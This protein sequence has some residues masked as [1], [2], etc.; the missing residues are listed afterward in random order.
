MGREKSL[1]ENGFKPKYKERDVGNSS[2]LIPESLDFGIETF[3]RSVGR[4]MLKVVGYGSVV[5]LHGLNYRVEKLGLIVKTYDG[6]GGKLL[7]LSI[8]VA[9]KI[10]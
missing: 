8:F 9:F 7:F 10:K 3:G 6:N 2:E 1:G 4:A 5:V